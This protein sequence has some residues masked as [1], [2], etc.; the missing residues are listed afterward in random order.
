MCDCCSHMDCENAPWVGQAGSPGC[1]VGWKNGLPSSWTLLR[2]SRACY[3]TSFCPCGSPHHPLLPCTRLLVQWLKPGVHPAF[4]PEHPLPALATRFESLS[5]MRMHLF[6]ICIWSPPVHPCTLLLM[7]WLK[8]RIHPTTPSRAS[9]AYLHTTC[10]KLPSTHH[11][12]Y[13]F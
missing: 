13:V 11:V 8:P 12:L 1:H 2:R 6:T 5:S 7:Q 3:P 4:H 9:A 10:R